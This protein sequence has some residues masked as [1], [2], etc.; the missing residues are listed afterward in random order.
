MT[1]RYQFDILTN[2]AM[3]PLTL[4]AGH[5]W[6]LMSPWG[7]NVKWYMKCFVYS[8]GDLKSSTLWSSQ[9]WTQF[10]QLRIEAWKSKYF[11][12][13]WHCDL[14][15]PVWCSNQLSYEA[16]HIGS[17]TFVSSNEPVRNVKW[18]L[19]LSKLW[20]FGSYEQQ[21]WKKCSPNCKWIVGNQIARYFS[22]LLTIYR[23]WPIRIRPGKYL[24]L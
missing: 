9:L 17:W 16:T 7:R 3:K 6:V 23:R 4:G 14:T 5:L 8:T 20:P 2:W 18:C 21:L 10:K 12:R 13:V 19:K 1:L 24:C 22:R 15:I 11:N